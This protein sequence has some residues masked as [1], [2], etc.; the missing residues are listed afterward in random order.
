MLPVADVVFDAVLLMLAAGE[1][2]FF[3]VN[4]QSMSK[5][6]ARLTDSANSLYYKVQSFI[7]GH[8]W[9]VTPKWVFGI[10]LLVHFEKFVNLLILFLDDCIHIFCH[11]FINVFLISF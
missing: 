1:E 11:N 6:V 3:T 8:W 7:E 4:K 5:Q 9:K 2:L 10:I